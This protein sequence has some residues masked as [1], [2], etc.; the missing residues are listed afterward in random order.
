MPKW[1]IYEIWPCEAL[2]SLQTDIASSPHQ[3]S[4]CPLL[5]PCHRCSNNVPNAIYNAYV[6]GHN[7]VVK[8]R[9]TA[10]CE[11]NIVIR[12]MQKWSFINT[13]SQSYFQRCFE[14]NN[15]HALLYHCGWFTII[16]N[17]LNLL[18]DTVLYSSSATAFQTLAKVQRDHI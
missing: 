14:S 5:L 9:G 18:L 16:I 10:W 3:I 7:L 15:N 1:L 2:G 4:L 13:D 17:I 6:H 8:C 12:P 11:T